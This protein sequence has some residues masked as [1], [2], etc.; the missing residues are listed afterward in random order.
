M[1]LTLYAKV[2]DNALSITHYHLIT[3]FRIQ[4][5]QQH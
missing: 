1:F 3:H 5:K 4:T 2:Q